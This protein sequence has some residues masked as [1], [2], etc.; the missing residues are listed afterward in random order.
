MRVQSNDVTSANSQNY[1]WRPITN[2]FYSLFC[3]VQSILFP[4]GDFRFLC[5][6]KK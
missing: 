5:H 4:I 1:T 3:G 6:R 2:K